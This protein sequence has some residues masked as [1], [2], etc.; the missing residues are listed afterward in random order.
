MERMREAWSQEPLGNRFLSLFLGLVINPEGLIK[1]RLPLQ[2]LSDLPL[3]LSS[4]GGEAQLGPS[5]PGP[6]SCITAR[7]PDPWA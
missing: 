6:P 1:F 7:P 2:V 5:P 4:P 3:G